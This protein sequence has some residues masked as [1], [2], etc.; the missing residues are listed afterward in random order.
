MSRGKILIKE[1]LLIWDPWNENSSSD[2]TAFFLTELR[3]WNTEMLVGGGRGAG[4]G[5]NRAAVLCALKEQLKKKG[6]L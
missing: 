5:K 4:G 6:G 2:V 1:V 3:Q